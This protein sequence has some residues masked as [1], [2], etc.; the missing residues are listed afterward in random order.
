MITVRLATSADRAPLARIFHDMEAYYEGAKAVSVAVAEAA[1]DRFVFT[2]GSGVQVM[3]AE[4]GGRFVAMASFS[5]T[6]PS[7]DLT[8]GLFVKDVYV[9]VGARN[10]RLGEALLRAIARHARDRGVTRIDWGVQETN[11]PAMALYERIGARVKEGT[12]Y[13]RLEGPAL[14]RLAADDRAA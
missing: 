4:E 13:M 2:P 1:L 12:H 11:A 3:V 7:Q 5:T 6:F 9:A 10:R 14:D 8:G